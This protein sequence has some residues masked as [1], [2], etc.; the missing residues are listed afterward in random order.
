MLNSLQYNHFRGYV[1]V[2]LLWM[3]RIVFAL[4]FQEY[5]KE[6]IYATPIT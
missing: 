3:T 2:W 5:Y 6:D 1:C 4:F